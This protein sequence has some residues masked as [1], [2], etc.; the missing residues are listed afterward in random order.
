[1]FSEDKKEEEKIEI[2]LESKDSPTSITDTPS[3]CDPR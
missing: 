3:P 2:Q 1:M